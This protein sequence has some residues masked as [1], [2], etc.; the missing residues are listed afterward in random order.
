MK[1]ISVLAIPNCEPSPL[2]FPSDEQMT[3][4]TGSALIDASKGYVTQDQ[5][6]VMYSL[7][8]AQKDNL[9]SIVSTRTQIATLLRSLLA[10]SASVDSVKTQVLALSG[11]HGNWMGQATT[12]TRRSSPRSTRH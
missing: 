9:N 8:A 10:S 5:A 12:N 4:T 11:M 2:R 7:V 1:P 6:T 3:A